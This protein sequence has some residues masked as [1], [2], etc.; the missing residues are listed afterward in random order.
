MNDTKYLAIY[1]NKWVSDFNNYVG[2][3]LSVLVD[4]I[5]NDDND[6]ND[7]TF[8]EIDSSLLVPKKLGYKLED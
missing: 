6:P 3:S 2:N 5:R 8:Y 4:A 1:A 7:Y